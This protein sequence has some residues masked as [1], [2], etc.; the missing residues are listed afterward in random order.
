[1]ARDAAAFLSRARCDTGTVHIPALW[2]AA[3]RSPIIMAMVK[4]YLGWW[5]VGLARTQEPWLG[6]N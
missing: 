6:L 1:M 4:M 2:A 3:T 5:W